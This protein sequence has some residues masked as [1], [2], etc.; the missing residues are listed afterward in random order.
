M[1]YPEKLTTAKK[2][3][4]VH[5]ESIKVEGIPFDLAKVELEQK[6]EEVRKDPEQ[7]IITNRYK[8]GCIYEGQFEGTHKH[9]IGIFTWPA[10]KAGP[11]SFI[12]EY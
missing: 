10:G 12:G 4:L 9:G 8:G 3:R 11:A 2:G 1:N 5:S 7:K 6:L